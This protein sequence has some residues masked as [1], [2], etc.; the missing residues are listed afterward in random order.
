MIVDMINTRLIYSAL[1][2]VLVLLL[3]VTCQPSVAFT[4]DGELKGF[5]IGENKTLFSFG[6]F[7]VV[8]AI[9][10]FYIFCIIDIMFPK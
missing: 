4:T 8:F 2:Y 3:V 5:G 6:L 9:L 7:S 10:S 1:F